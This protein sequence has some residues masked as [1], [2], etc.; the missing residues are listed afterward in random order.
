MSLDNTI[1]KT[2]TWVNNKYTREAIKLLCKIFKY[3]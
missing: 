2:L 3:K 1:R